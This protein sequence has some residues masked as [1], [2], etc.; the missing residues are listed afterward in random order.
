MKLKT[1]NSWKTPLDTEGERIMNGTDQFKRATTILVLVAAVAILGC[2]EQRK[3]EVMQTVSLKERTGEVTFQG[4]PLTLLGAKPA[5]GAQ[6][7]DAVLVDKQLKEVNLSSSFGKTV[8]V[9]AVPSLDT[10]VCDAQ[11]RRFNQEAAT[12][13]DVVIVTVSMD[14]PFAQSRWCGAAGVDN[15]VV[16]SDHRA[17]SFGSNYGVLI[18]ELRL[19]ARSI[20]VIA[21]DG[22]LKYMEIVPE[23]TQHPDYDAAL[24]AAGKK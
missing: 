22:K 7:P 5:V 1:R 17:A 14:L 19:L 18:K 15:L 13:P 11:T 6:A 23:M 2:R 3:E 16:L 9:S 21:P 20:F 24:K 8:L 10:G 4:N 12:L